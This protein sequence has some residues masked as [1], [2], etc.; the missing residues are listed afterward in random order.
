MAKP[1]VHFSREELEKLYYEE[2]RSAS[3]VAKL[4]GCTSTTIKNYLKKYNMRVKS[5]SEVMSGRVLKQEHRD[6]VVKTLKSGLKGSS[7]PNWKGGRSWRGR[8]KESSYIIIRVDGKYVPE[9]RYVMEKHLGRKLTTQEE[10]HHRNGNKHN[11][12][13][14]NLVILTKSEH[15]HMH[16][17]D[18]VFRQ[19]KSNT[20]KK[21][22]ANKFWSTRVSS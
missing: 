20:M 16:N 22:R 6:K 7:N 19:Q 3:E 12:D 17:N 15:A 9:H 11:N 1:R 8:N 13:I 4:L 18:P 14:S 2:N 5:S 10:V 21:T